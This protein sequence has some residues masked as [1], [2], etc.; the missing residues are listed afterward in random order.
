MALGSH[1]SEVAQAAS[2]LRILS[3]D[4]NLLD[5]S[6]VLTPCNALPRQFFDDDEV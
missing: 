2:A 4:C 3:A 1:T 6:N 5:Y